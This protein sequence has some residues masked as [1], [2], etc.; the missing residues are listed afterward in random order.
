[1][2]TLYTSVKERSIAYITF[3]QLPYEFQL[4]PYLDEILHS[5]DHTTDA[6]DYLEDDEDENNWSKDM[7][8]A[9]RLPALAP[10]KSLLLL[11]TQDPPDV[12]PYANLREP[13]MNAEDRQLAEGLLKFLETA[14]IY[15]S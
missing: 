15:V 13:Q 12:D 8:F 4:P 9:W 6:L 1:M 5:D 11:D 2:K 10:W 14:S 7:T 3:H